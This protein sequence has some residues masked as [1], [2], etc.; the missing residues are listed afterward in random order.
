MPHAM[1]SLAHFLATTQPFDTLPPDTRQEL[2][3]Q[4][5]LLT[6]KTGS[7]LI[8]ASQ[9]VEHLHLVFSGE[10][11]MLQDDGATA[12][13]LGEG[14]F[15]GYRAL[16]SSE[17]DQYTVKAI[18]DSTV[19]QVPG[20][21]FQDLCQRFAAFKRFFQPLQNDNTRHSQ[22]LRPD[23]EEHG[24][25]LLTTPLPD[26]I[27]REPITLPCDTSIREAA[28]VMADRRISSML[29]VDQGKLSGIVTDRDLRIRVVAAGRSYDDPL[30][31]IMT[32]KPV[33]VPV[34]AFG[35]EALLA[36]ARNNVHHIP[37]VDGEHVAGMITATDLL[38]RRSSS[39]V[40]LVSD[41]YNRSTVAEL[42]KVSARLLL[43]LRSLVESNATAHSIGHVISA[44]GEAITCRLLQLAEQKLG[45]PP[46]PYAWLAAGSLARGEQ[47]AL[48]DQDNCLVLSDDYRPDQHSEYFLALSRY[49]SDG[50]NECGYVYCP[51][52][53][54]ATNSEW[55]QPLTQW[56]RYF[57]RWIEQPEPK[58]LM[59]SSVFFDLRLMHGEQS[60]LDELQGHILSKSKTNRIF[61]AYMTG[62]ALSHQPPLGLFRN[63]VLVKGGENDHTL[64][65]KHS[66]VVPIIDLA[67]IYCLAAGLP[68]VNTWDRL[69]TAA[70]QGELSARGAADLRDALEFISAVR[71]RHQAQRIKEGQAPNNFVA[72]DELS[73]FER[74]HLKDAFALVRTMQS[75]LAQ[76][77]Q[78]GRLG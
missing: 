23:R 32:K 58:A 11:A 30:S 14:S 7:I 73:H 54:M 71:L 10:L 21:V 77:F 28:K 70:G 16:L 19:V 9:T 35:F 62:N 6:V 45:T 20:P 33:T 36:M 72:P 66:G 39:A 52:D 48:S 37:I 67:R 41:V 4:I 27:V 76:R 64:D 26:L 5:D 38:E 74:N 68:E 46:V 13:T 51:G 61:L 69:E 59:L 24:V 40:Y 42:A 57:D 31:A 34:T 55:R 1:E 29:V 22:T 47:T 53:V 65:L 63:F 2:L 3:G 18:S 8:E 56:K 75:V 43:V 25:N 44:V 50:L 49:V 15:Y 78:A 17:Q 12:S 60:L